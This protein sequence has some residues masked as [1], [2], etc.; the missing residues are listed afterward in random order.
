MSEYIAPQYQDG[1]DL[2]GFIPVHRK[3]QRTAARFVS[4]ILLK[5]DSIEDTIRGIHNYVTKQSCDVKSIHKLR[6]FNITMSV[7]L[8]VL[9]S[10]SEVLL[11]TGFWPEGIRCRLWV[12]N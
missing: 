8:I 12:E 4:G 6:K 10:E 7:K 9:E 2:L 1:D 5:N 11:G 3:R